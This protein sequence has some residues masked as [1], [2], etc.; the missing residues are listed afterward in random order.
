[1]TTVDT[2]TTTTNVPAHTNVGGDGKE[3]EQA[4]DA[5]ATMSMKTEEAPRPQATTPIRQPVASSPPANSATAVATA[6]PATPVPEKPVLAPVGLG[7][8]D[9]QAQ[10][11]AC[12]KVIPNQIADGHSIVQGHVGQ[13]RMLIPWTPGPD[14]AGVL[15]SRCYQK[16]WRT[17]RQRMG[18]EDKDAAAEK[19]PREPYVCLCGMSFQSSQLKAAHCRLCQKYREVADQEQRQHPCQASP[20]RS[21]VRELLPGHKRPRTMSELQ[22]PRPYQ[23][24]QESGGLF[25]PMP[26]KVR[27]ILTPAMLGSP[28]VAATP[29]G[30]TAPTL[31]M[32][33]AQA[34][35]LS[36]IEVALA[37]VQLAQ[38][39]QTTRL[40]G[41]ID[42]VHYASL[43]KMVATASDETLIAEV[44]HLILPFALKPLVPCN[45]SVCATPLVGSPQSK[46]SKDECPAVPPVQP[47]LP[48][49][50]PITQPLPPA[51]VRGVSLPPI[52]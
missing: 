32:D 19:V 12:G 11:S 50:S 23:R 18:T 46:C 27:A 31:T 15:C 52:Q 40:L 22:S 45:A 42:V 2:T 25:T 20:L 16:N 39:L 24:M 44:A 5:L 14:G 34:S 13:F 8:G 29:L 7:C 1:M 48:E 47:Q 51:A 10:C 37:R 49:L 30:R 35:V 36:R 17:N 9:K 6:A 41:Q 33:C 26:A 21:T 3:L 4:A 38:L 43:A 28:A